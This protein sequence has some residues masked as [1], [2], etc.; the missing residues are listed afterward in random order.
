MRIVTTLIAF[1]FLF[2]ADAEHGGQALDQFPQEEWDRIV[3]VD[4]TGLFLVS[5]ATAAV[6]R[7]QGSGRIINVA[8]IGGLIP[9]RLQS[10][11]VAA[12][13]GVINLTK[14]IVDQPIEKRWDLENAIDS[15]VRKSFGLDDTP[16]TPLPKMGGQ[17]GQLVD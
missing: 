3:G 6:M 5:K 9:L 7:Q 14:S 8:S 1:A 15:I 10:P 12:K 16:T 17:V 2:A 11:F 13:A 4:M